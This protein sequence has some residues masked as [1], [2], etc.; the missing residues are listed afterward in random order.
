MTLDVSLED[1]TLIDI[2]HFR[3]NWGFTVNELSNIV[4]LQMSAKI[5]S[6]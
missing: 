5:I 1:I 2:P 6:I 4:L 3:K